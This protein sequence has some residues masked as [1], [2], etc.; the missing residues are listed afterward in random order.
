M[1]SERTAA[2][3]LIE[4][5]VSVAIATVLAG[6]AWDG[7]NHLRRTTARNRAAM[8]L[9]AEAAYLHARLSTS[10][11]Q[12]LQQTQLRVEV[13][14][15]DPAVYGPGARTVRFVGMLEASRRRPDGGTTFNGA[16]P[17]TPVLWFA[18]EWRPPRLA[19]LAVNASACGSLWYAQSSSNA[20]Q[21]GC[22]VLKA[23][24]T[25][26]NLQFAQLPQA[27]RARQRV[28]DDNDL[29]LVEGADQA[30]AIRIAGDRVDL[31]GGILPGG[32]T[33]PDPASLVSPQVRA[34]TIA[35]VDY[36]GWV[37]TATR[38]GVA[39]ADA[40][41]AAVDPPASAAWWTAGQRVVDGQYRDGRSAAADAGESV[42]QARPGLFRLSF[43][44]VDQATGIEMPFTFSIAPDLGSPLA[45][46][47]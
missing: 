39:V 44:L 41:G 17:S 33:M 28:L 36:H 8:D 5:L 45:C 19:D 1:R 2:F 4:V 46:G 24:G 13:D 29:R 30:P 35:W 25:P 3:T 38:D 6:L 43:V 31:L 21:W 47:I 34:F 26:M 14:A 32:K 9:A 20:R 40:T 7:F 27:R 15:L 22:N 18:W 12:S 42:P 10:I 16:D 23:D 11:V 37:T